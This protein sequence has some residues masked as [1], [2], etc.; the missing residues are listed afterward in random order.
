MGAACFDVRALNQL[1]CSS[2]LLVSASAMAL[3]VSV[4]EGL[5]TCST[6]SFIRMTDIQLSTHEVV[7]H[8]SL[9]Q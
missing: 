7:I 9:R 4:G 1:G 3:A 2:R 6:P 5:T 8:F